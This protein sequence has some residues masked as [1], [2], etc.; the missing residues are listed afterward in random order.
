MKLGFAALAI[1][2]AFIG[3]DSVRAERSENRFIID[4]VSSLDGFAVDHLYDISQDRAGYMWFATADGLHR[5]DGHEIRQYRHGRS[6]ATAPD[7][8]NYRSIIEDNLGRLWFFPRPNDTDYVTRLNPQSRV[9]DRVPIKA[10]RQLSSVLT[11]LND[12]KGRYWF[13]GYGGLQKM[14]AGGE[15]LEQIWPQI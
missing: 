12:R 3:S 10:D 5:Y 14:E 9:F 13:G 1:S 8:H 15:A 11:M 2:I 7:F 4:R 6:Q